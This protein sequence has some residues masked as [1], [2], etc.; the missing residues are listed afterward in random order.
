MIDSDEKPQKAENPSEQPKKETGDANEHK[1]TDSQK[2]SKA[3]CAISLSNFLSL[4][5]S[6]CLV[7]AAFLTFFAICAQVWIYNCQL[8]QMQKSTNAAASAAKA[9]EDSVILAREN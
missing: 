4:L 5:F 2:S 8:K 3:M 9:A 7:L 1:N 6:A